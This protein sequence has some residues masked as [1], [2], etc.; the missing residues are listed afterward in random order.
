MAI[1]VTGHVMVADR[2]NDRVKLLDA[3]DLTFVRDLIGAEQFFKRPQ[4]LHYDPARGL[5]YAGLVAGD[6]LVFKVII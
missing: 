1:D 4:R 6:T 3:A 5:L 2:R